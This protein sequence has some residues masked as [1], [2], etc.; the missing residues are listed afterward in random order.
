MSTRV[1]VVGGSGFVGRSVIAQLAVRDVEAVAVPAPR[2]SCAPDSTATAWRDNTTTDQVATIFANFDIIINCAGDPDASSRDVPRLFGANGALPGVVAA[3]ARRAGAHRFVHV[4]SAVVQGGA[5]ILDASLQV[6]GHS[7]YARSKIAGERAVEA[8]ESPP[9]TVIYRPASVHSPERRVTRSI[10]RL[11]RSPLASVV[12]SGDD[13]TPQAHID[14]VGNAIA[15]LALHEANEP[16]AVV[17][18]PWEGW[19]TAELMR[20]FGDGREPVHIPGAMGPKLRYLLRTA[21]RSPRLAPNARRVEMMWFGQR[22]EASWLT[23]NG[24]V[25][26]VGRDRWQQMLHQPQDHSRTAQRKQD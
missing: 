14:N 17:I 22:Q 23:M 11:A 1:A 8:A 16:P 9:C 25:P 21:V 24:W 3:A 6:N 13:P 19:T 7:V 18:H 12:G 20:V 10:Q 4:S 2:L 15:E 5:E 26:P